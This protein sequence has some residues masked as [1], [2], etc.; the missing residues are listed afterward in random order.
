MNLMPPNKTSPSSISSWL[1]TDDSAA[2]A[3]ILEAIYSTE[4]QLGTEPSSSDP[5]PLPVALRELQRDLRASE[6]LVEYVLDDPNSYVLAVTRNTV[7]RYSLPP[8]DL[9][10][11]EATQYRST[12][13]QQKTDPALGQRLY[14]GLLGGIPEFQEKQDLIVG[15]RWQAPPSAVFCLGE[16]RAL[17]SD[18]PSGYSRALGNRAQ[19]AQA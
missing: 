15:A 6:L 18:F 2:R 14:D 12:L 19:Y 17:H 5:A 11:Q 10:E 3:H 4:Q 13:K 1:N 7:H 9:L 8:R 16:C